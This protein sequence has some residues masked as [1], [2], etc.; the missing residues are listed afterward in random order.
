[1][2]VT[3][4]QKELRK[5]VRG[6]ILDV[7]NSEN[8]VPR[9][10]CEAY[11]DTGVDY[12]EANSANYL[13]GQRE[14]GKKVNDYTY[15]SSDDDFDELIQRTAEK[16]CFAI[17]SKDIRC[18]SM[19]NDVKKA[20]RQMLPIRETPKPQGYW[21][22]DA[23]YNPREPPSSS[24]P[25]PRRV[26]P[27]PPQQTYVRS[28]GRTPRPLLDAVGPNPDFG[29]GYNSPRLGR[30]SRAEQ[31]QI[32]ERR[33]RQQQWEQNEK[34]QR[35][36]RKEETEQRQKETNDKWRE[37]NWTRDYVQDPR[38]TER[39]L[40]ILE[41][42]LRPLWYERIR[43]EIAN[44]DAPIA[45]KIALLEHRLK[46]EQFAAR[47]SSSREEELLGEDEIRELEEQIQQLQ[48]VQPNEQQLEEMV[49]EK[50]S[51]LR[52]QRRQKQGK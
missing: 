12:F 49:A 25:P 45:E 20:A 37:A 28:P 50:L 43:R 33:E 41:D 1:M 46:G 6:A 18:G 39:D 8:S 9:N 29:Y 52:E 40:E 30:V 48:K 16:I 21:V 42:R 3:L 51:N 23:P 36:R 4:T 14:R 27:P 31:N 44:E 19:A 34:Q 32:D 26:P 17:M 13:L 11:A 22:Y 38:L 35:K 15:K 7:C 47:N 5:I 2:T 10:E 24:N